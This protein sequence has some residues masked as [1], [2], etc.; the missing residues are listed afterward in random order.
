MLLIH[1]ERHEPQSTKTE[2]VEGYELSQAGSVRLW[3]YR[4]GHE[5]T[6]VAGPGSKL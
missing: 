6:V 1:T 3:L 5:A 4:G 2:R